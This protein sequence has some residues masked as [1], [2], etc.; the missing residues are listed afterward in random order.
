[1]SLRSEDERRDWGQ[2]PPSTSPG[3]EVSRDARAGRCFFAAVVECSAR[4]PARGRAVSELLSPDREDTSEEEGDETQSDVKHVVGNQK[5]LR[6]AIDDLKL[7]MLR[8]RYD[9]GFSWW[10]LLIPAVDRVLKAEDLIHAMRTMLGAQLLVVNS[11]CGYCGQ[12]RH[13]AQC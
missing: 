3:A 1:M 4:Q 9:Q 8:L 7:K 2:E 13:D 6:Q 5:N 10:D 12:Q 11:M